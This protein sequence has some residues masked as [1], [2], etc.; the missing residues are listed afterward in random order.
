M[1]VLIVI[2]IFANLGGWWCPYMVLL[3]SVHM[4][5]KRD[6]EKVERE[7]DKWNYMVQICMYFVSLLH[8][9]LF[10]SEIGTLK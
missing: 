4:R 10:I 9:P 8:F 1:L 6:N 5:K 3:R 2:W 7:R